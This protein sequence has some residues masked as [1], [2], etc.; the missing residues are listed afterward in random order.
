MEGWTD[1]NL[2]LTTQQMDDLRH[3]AEEAAKLASQGKATPFDTLNMHSEPARQSPSFYQISEGEQLDVIGHRLTL[4]NAP[5]EPVRL[6]T[7][8]KRAPAR[9]K[10]ATKSAKG[11][12][13]PA[14]PPPP[15]NWQK[16]SRP[17]AKDLPGLAQVA[18]A[19]APQYDDWYLVRTRDGKVGWVLS[20]MLMMS[21]PDEVAQYAEGH[22][23]TAYLPLGEV[24]DK[25]DQQSKYNWIWTTASA[26]PHPFEFDSFRVFVWSTKRHHYETA[27]IERNVQGYYPIEAWSKPGEEEN[28]FSVVLRDK[29]GKLYKETFGFAGYHVRMISKASYDTPPDLPE[30]RE[31]RDFDQPAAP[32][33]ASV[34]IGEKLTALRKK[35]FGK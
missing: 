22:R 29:D 15:R 14:G 25:E 33:Q 5:P 1:A 8:V 31:S 21:I 12:P 20:H 35:W 30:V 10:K 23:I 32:A 4:H 2:L 28:S 13:M 26:G 3:L 34:G 9:K 24:T 18:P 7:T 6:T 27:Y 11:P 17:N 16:L 19:A